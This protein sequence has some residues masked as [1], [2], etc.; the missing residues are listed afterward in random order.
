MGASFH[1]SINDLLGPRLRP[2]FQAIMDPLNDVYMPW[3]RIC[4]VALFAA[5][6]IWVLTLRPEYVNLDAPRKAWYA[7]LRLWTALAMLPHVLVYLFV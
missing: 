4:A 5:A 7:D 1:D 6:M 3:A 2:F